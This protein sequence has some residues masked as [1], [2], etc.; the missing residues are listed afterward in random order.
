MK[1]TKFVYNEKGKAIGRVDEEGNV[2][3]LTGYPS[4]S[5]YHTP[6]GVAVN[7]SHQERITASFD[8]EFDED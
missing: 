4:Y 5:H 7:K 8:V 3:T 6:A 2:Y 1:S